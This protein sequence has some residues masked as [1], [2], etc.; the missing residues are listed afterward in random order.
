MRALSRACLVAV[1]V[2]LLVA[3]ACRAADASRER[4][5]WGQLPALPDELGVAGAYSGISHDA[6]IVA[7]GANFPDPDW[8]SPKVFS[9]TIWVLTQSKDG[10]AILPGRNSAGFGD[11]RYRWAKM[12]RLPR[13]LAYGAVVTYRDS[14][15]CLGGTDGTA[16]YRDV[17]SLT[18]DPLEQKVMV[19]ELPALISPCAYG[20][21]TVAGDSIFVAGGQKEPGLETAMNNF[22]TLDMSQ[23][24][25]SGFLW[26]EL[27][28]WPGP[29]RAFNLAVAQH[30]GFSDCVYVISGRRTLDGKLDFLSD[31]YEFD[32]S[33]VGEAGGRSWR[34]VPDSPVCVMAGTAVPVGQSH[35]FVFGGADGS[36]AARVNELRDRHPGFPRRVSAFHTI[37]GSWV[38]VGTMPAS[39]VSTTAV[40]W[41]GMIV[42]PSGEVR[43]RMRSPKVWVAKL[44][45]SETSFGWVN[46]IVLFGY[47]LSMVAIGVF[48]ARKN[49]NTDDFFRGGKRM[50]WW[51]AGCSIFATMLSSLTYT[52]IPS[53]AYAQ[54]WVYLVGNLMIPVVAILAV[55]LAL[56]FYRRIDATSA[57][58]YLGKRFNMHVRLFGSASFTLFHVFR[59]A[60][61]MSLTGLALAAATP[62][63]PSQ[64][65]LIIG[66]LSIIYCTL[67]GIEAVIWT[68]A[69]QTVVLL[70]GAGLAFFLL[71]LGIEGGLSGLVES[72]GSAGKFRVA[73]LHWDI[74]SAQIALWVV[75]LGAIGQ[76]LSSYTADQ[77]VVQRYMTTPSLRNAARSI[78][79]N[80]LLSIPASF[81][82]F[83]MGAALYVFYSNHPERLD[84]TITTDQ[85]FPFF[86]ANEMPIGIAG[87]IV[88][89]VFAAAQSTVS[90][91]MN[92]TATTVVTD[93]LRPFDLCSS[94]RGYLNAARL[95][96]LLMGVLGMLL[97]LAFVDPEILS[98]FDAF[99]VV[100]GLFM[101][102]LGGL[103]LLGV[104]TRRAHGRGAF[105]GAIVGAGVMAVLW[106]YTPVNG[107]IYASAGISV[108]F[109][110]G[111][112]SSLILPEGKSRDLTGLT[113][114]TLHS[115]PDMGQE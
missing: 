36:L 56:P 110:V 87:L 46:Y 99:I 54:D 18:W 50:I 111:Y 85:I 74:G 2:A 33:L 10:E 16:V 81:L 28:G 70:G 15:I 7:G 43:P 41:N 64:A 49:R 82:F 65:V 8:E 98:L 23:R 66:V 58:E 78:W 71:L 105:M 76:N 27:P 95:L 63:T 53:K 51:A 86:I 34:R 60:V 84:P 55:Y 3:A 115:Q 40:K 26:R 104:A 14:V 94:E 72:A 30:N 88:A 13:P 42:I 52:G 79:T 91:S 113:L 45:S 9:D 112:V 93:F 5:H 38:D 80:A 6:L 17:F 77:A 1:S 69:I 47:L 108:C 59:M 32:T 114:F 90:T 29:E 103:F 19:K 101:G 73:N 31:V 75:V 35:L 22:W 4:F 100:I 21:A 44:I 96:T 61:I 89:G 107:Y 62:L 68:D 24:G 83:G 109:V 48:F 57:Y 11:A 92:S 106:Y 37:T 102:V 25:S 12:G 20:A 67:G 39:H 97:G